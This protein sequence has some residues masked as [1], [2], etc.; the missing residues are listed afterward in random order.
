MYSILNIKYDSA[1]ESQ[2]GEMTLLKL[3]SVN[4]Q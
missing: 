3:S 1:R 4:G 2:S